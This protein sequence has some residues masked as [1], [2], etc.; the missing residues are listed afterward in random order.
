MLDRILASLGAGPALDAF[1]PQAAEPPAHRRPLD[2]AALG[3]YFAMVLWIGFCLQGMRKTGE[4]FSMA[5][6]EMNPARP[7]GFL[8]RFNM[9]IPERCTP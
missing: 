5:G 2:I 1:R 8:F 4:A 9:R 3:I 7:G 6:R